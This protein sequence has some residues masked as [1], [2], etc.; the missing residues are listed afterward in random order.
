M[1]A[2]FNPAT[3]LAACASG[4]KAALR[5][6]YEREAPRMVGVAMR[7]LKRRALAEEAVQDA[8]VLVWRNAAS[9]DPARGDALPWLYTILRNRCLSILRT[10]NRMETREEPVGEEQASEEDD[11]ETVLSKLSDAKALKHCLTKLEPERRELVLLAFV[12]GL[13]HG[14]LAGRLGVPLGTIKSW[15]RRSLISLKECLG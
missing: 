4:D 9:F 11:P 3:A 6:I 7:L 12:Q 8:F 1:N 13:T 10:E 15:I 2:H 14:E 5:L